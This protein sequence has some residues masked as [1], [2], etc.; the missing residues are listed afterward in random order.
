MNAKKEDIPNIFLTKEEISLS[1][2]FLKRGYVILPIKEIDKFTEMQYFIAKTG[3]EKLG[4]N[5]TSPSVFL[6][7]IHQKVSVDKLNQFRLSVIH[8]INSCEWFRQYYFNVAKHGLEVLV[9]NELAMQLRINLSI[10]MPQDNSSLLPVHADVWSGDSPFEVVAWIPYVNC[11]GSKAMYILP[12]NINEQLCSNFS[13]FALLNGCDL[14]KEI[15]SDLTWI[16]I[17]EGEILIFNQNLPHGNI[18]NVENETRWSSNCRFKSI[19]SPYGDKKIGEFFE[20]ITM[21]AASRTGM[22]YQFPSLLEEK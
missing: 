1:N 11:Y 2:E 5:F 6:N 10:Q 21:R 7:S 8:D 18:I 19:F 13:K 15:E 12:P 16:E 14:F 20:P 9:G 22:S 4:L 17:K 3:S